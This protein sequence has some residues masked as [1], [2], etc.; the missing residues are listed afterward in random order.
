MTSCA[1]VV[2]DVLFENFCAAVAC[3][4]RHACL[5]VHYALG[6][7][8]VLDVSMCR[9]FLCFGRFYALVDAVREEV[10]TY[11]VFLWL[12]CSRS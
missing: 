12:A 1:C 8:Y 4:F 2:G 6:C 7:F 11:C 5:C 10:S 3:K 9:L